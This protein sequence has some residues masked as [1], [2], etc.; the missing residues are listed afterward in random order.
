MNDIHPAVL[1]VAEW[2]GLRVH[3]GACPK[4]VGHPPTHVMFDREGVVYVDDGRCLAGDVLHECLH[5]VLGPDTLTEEFELMAYEYACAR[6]L[7][8]GKEYTEWRRDFAEYG[9]DWGDGEDTI[10]EGDEV[11]HSQE[12]LDGCEMGAFMRGW[13]NEDGAPVQFQGLHAGYTV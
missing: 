1:K 12:W 7:L 11:F 4:P 9:F 8:D 5:A 3:V 10:G 13:L 2:F 6:L